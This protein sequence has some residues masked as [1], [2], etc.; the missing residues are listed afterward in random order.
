MPTEMSVTAVHQGEMRILAQA[1][2]RQLLMDYPLKG[3]DPAGFKP[4]ETL[5]ASLAG[6]AGD[7][8]AILLRKTRQ[9]FIGL[10]VEV[11]AQRRD[12]H[13]TIFTQIHM[14]FKV[15]GSNLVQSQVQ[16]VLKEA[17]ERVCPVWAM[18]KASTPIA[19]SLTVIC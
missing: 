19:T 18:L 14:D 9:P 4:L 12:E 5:L 3:E 1:G 10:Q 8:L 2:T 15:R 16:D 13:P 6:C 17:E 11:R 7:T